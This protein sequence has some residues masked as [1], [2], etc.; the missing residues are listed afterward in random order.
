MSY[1][2]I[3]ANTPTPNTQRLFQSVIKG[4]QQTGYPVVSKSPLEASA[5]DILSASGVILGTTEHFGYMSG[6]IK[7]LLERIY[8]PCMENTDGMPWALY[9][10]AGLDGTGAINSVGKIVS[11]M[12]WKAV[13]EPLLLHGSFTEEFL[14]EAEALGAGMAEGLKLGIF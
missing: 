11:G 5:E 2:L 10:K 12:R 3:I 9:V 13:Q 1:L 8:Y 7:D 14:G 6:L 4:A